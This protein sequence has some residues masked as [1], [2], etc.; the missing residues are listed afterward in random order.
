[1]HS[2]W[3]PSLRTKLLLLAFK[4]TLF[5][6][7]MKLTCKIASTETHIKMAVTGLITSLHK[8]NRIVTAT[9]VYE[10]KSCIP[11]VDEHNSEFKFFQSK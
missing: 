2:I 3:C 1:M 7:V 6:C 11:F 10:S 8:P 9:N 4:A 5:V